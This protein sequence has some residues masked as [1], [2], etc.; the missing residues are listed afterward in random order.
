MPFLNL[1]PSARRPELA[2]RA[3]LLGAL[4]L[5]ATLIYAS[6]FGVLYRI[7]PHAEWLFGAPG[8]PPLNI[9]LSIIDIDPVRE[10]LQVHLDFATVE[11]PYGTHYPGVPA[12]DLIVHV[13]DGNSIQDIALQAQKNAAPVTLRVSLR[14]T[15]GDYPFD[16]Y[17]GRMTVS[18]TRTDGGAAQPVELTVWPVMSHWTI[19]LQ[20]AAPMLPDDG[21]ISLSVRI[22]RPPPFVVIAIAV[23]TAMGLVGLSGL[24]IGSL[25]FLG[26]RRVE[27]TLTSALGA[28]VFAVPALRGALPGVPPLGGHADVLVFVW[29]ELA[30][31]LGLTLFVITWARRG[32][33]P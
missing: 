7:E 5:I 17:D 26:V 20:R 4:L 13:G 2:G 10:E 18:A 19:E 23:Y 3:L 31:I 30:V 12:R 6:V 9:Y 21:G 8:S 15:V 24:T 25:V 33:A 22:R 29:V 14:G 32:P 27:A 16:V 1:P 11:G 28:M